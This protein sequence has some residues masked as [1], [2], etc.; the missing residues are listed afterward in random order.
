MPTA[1]VATA[2]MPKN[3]QAS[4]ALQ[5][6]TSMGANPWEKANLEKGPSMP[7]SAAAAMM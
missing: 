7:H 2:C 3:P 6:A 5:K 4:K 1:R